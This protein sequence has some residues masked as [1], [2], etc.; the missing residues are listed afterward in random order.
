M[1]LKKKILIF[2]RLDILT[3]YY[4]HSFHWLLVPFL[5]IWIPIT[6]AVIFG[7]GMIR[8]YGL[9]SIFEYLPFPCFT[10]NGLVILTVTLLPATA[11]CEKS[12]RVWNSLR[13]EIAGNGRGRAPFFTIPKRKVKELRREVKALKPFGVRVGLVRAVRRIAILMSYYFI[14]NHIFTLLV[15]FPQESIVV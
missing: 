14:S 4:N 11:V 15:S 1:P 8:F 10:N 2:R 9:V 7:F 12:E 6:Y 13:R 3:T 5:F